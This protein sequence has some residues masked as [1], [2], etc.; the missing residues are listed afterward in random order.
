MSNEKHWE[1]CLIRFE[2]LG[3]FAPALAGISVGGHSTVD[4][5]IKLQNLQK[6][7]IRYGGSSNS[8]EW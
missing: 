3:L 8:T 4:L 2:H 5:T 7:V 6:V 1:G